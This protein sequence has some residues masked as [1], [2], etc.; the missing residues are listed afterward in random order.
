MLPCHFAYIKRN[1]HADSLMLCQQVTVSTGDPK[2]V[3]T[4]AGRGRPRMPL[5]RNN[6][7]GRTHLNI[8]LVE[9]TAARG[10]LSVALNSS[11]DVLH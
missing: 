6:P 3:I 7:G 8:A 10:K 1:F 9:V 5:L 11:H 2:V 4:C